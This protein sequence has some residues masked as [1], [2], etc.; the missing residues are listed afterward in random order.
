MID[1]VNRLVIGIDAAI[2]PAEVAFLKF[3]DGAQRLGPD[4]AVIL[5]ERIGAGQ[6]RQHVVERC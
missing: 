1:E 4:E 2:E 3:L 6:F 5:Q